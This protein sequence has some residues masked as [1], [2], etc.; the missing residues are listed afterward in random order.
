MPVT[1]INNKA[2]YVVTP[3]SNNWTRQDVMSEA[4]VLTGTLDN[5][6][7]QTHSV[8]V[9]INMAVSY[10]AELLRLSSSPFYGIYMEA[11]LE[12]TQ[13]PS[14][15]EWIDLGV[16]PAGGTVIPNSI[17][18]GIRRI[19]STAVLPVANP[20]VAPV[21]YDGNWTS[22]DI[23]N[24]VQ[25]N[26]KHNVQHRFSVAWQHHGSEIVIFAGKNIETPN[27]TGGNVIE[28]TVAD[29]TLKKEKTKI[30]VWA[31]RVPIL[32]DLLPMSNTTS[33]FFQRIDV[34][35]KY[36]KLVVQLAQ[37]S[38]LEQMQTQIPA[39]L[40]QEINQAV[41]AAQG[42]INQEIQLEAADRE[43]RKYGNPQKQGA[44]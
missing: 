32:D 18:S 25:Q 12:P 37:K 8:R 42:I 19:N 20:P 34:P 24:L 7:I 22:W 40:D 36:V 13:H 2:G 38:I 39:A 33:N 14:G 5:E 1:R 29:Y 41:A 26:N 44:M 31:N 30:V 27:Q 17:V 15:L 6:N 43:K 23:S 35:D 11:E 16:A 9:H 4:M 21:A 10:V 28:E 3:L